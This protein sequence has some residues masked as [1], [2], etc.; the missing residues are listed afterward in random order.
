MKA[1][2]QGGIVVAKVQLPRRLR[3]SENPTL[4]VHVR[5][6]LTRDSALL[7]GSHPTRPRARAAV[8]GGCGCARIPGEVDNA[9]E[10]GRV[11]RIGS[12]SCARKLIP[13]PARPACS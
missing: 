6:G 8:L 11:I 7:N 3:P 12:G 10:P 2:V 5:T 4:R 9:L 1:F 13:L